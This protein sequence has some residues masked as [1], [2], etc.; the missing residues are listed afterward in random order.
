M[1]AQLR[2]RMAPLAVSSSVFV[3]ALPNGE[4]SVADARS[5]VFGRWPHLFL[6]S[7]FHACETNVSESQAPRA[8]ARIHGT[9]PVRLRKS[10]SDFGPQLGI[11]ERRWLHCTSKANPGTVGNKSALFSQE[12]MTGLISDLVVPEERVALPPEVLEAKG[13]RGRSWAPLAAM[14]K[15]FSSSGSFGTGPPNHDAPS[16]PL[17]PPISQSTLIWWRESK[18]SGLPPPLSNLPSRRCSCEWEHLGASPKQ[19]WASG[20]FN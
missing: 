7:I 4:T 12:S 15:H 14:L 5:F 19:E 9:P 13:D 10:G 17:P 20:C 2:V 8:V 3:K 18:N 11:L 1:L 16:D 6:A